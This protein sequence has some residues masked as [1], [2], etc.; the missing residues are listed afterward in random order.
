MGSC[1]RTPGAFHAL[2][3]DGH[4]KRKIKER[5]R[6]SHRP[7]VAAWQAC[8]PQALVRRSIDEST[9]LLQAC[10]FSR[11]FQQGLSVGAFSTSTL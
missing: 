1:S 10:A 3:A 5:P 8:G 6:A 2:H 9:P 4:G 7:G 11:G